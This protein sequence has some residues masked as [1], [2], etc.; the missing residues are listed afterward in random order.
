MLLPNRLVRSATFEGLCDADGLPGA[1]YERLYAEL[2]KSGVGLIIT[3]FCYCSKEGSAI[4]PGQAGL[5]SDD[6]IPAFR[7]VTDAVHAG[8][9]RIAAQIAHTGR[10]TRRAAT[11]HAPLGVSA[12]RSCYF[13]EQPRVLT[14]EKIESIIE[15]L[16]RA[17]ARARAAGFDAVQL[18][19]AHGYLI[20]QF[21]L[22]SINDRRDAWGVKRALGIG[23]A[24][25]GR[26]IE[27]VRAECGEDY[28]L[29]VKVSGSDDLRPRFSRRQFVEL[30]RFLDG[31][32]VDGIEVSYGTMD[33]ALNIFRGSTIPY[34]AILEHDPVYR[35]R[36]AL[37]GR[38][39][40]LF[41][42]PY[43][44]R[45]LEPFSPAYNL[46]YARIA[47][48]N[49][50]AAVIAVGGFR[51]RKEMD[52]VLADGRA[53]FVA[54]CRPFIADRRFATRLRDEEGHVSR[55]ENCN[56]CAVRT[57]AGAATVCRRARP[58]RRAQV[59]RNNRLQDLG[60]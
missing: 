50:D 1:D 41:A 18:H 9:A 23:T 60:R 45:K 38:L 29:L 47:K 17:A 37:R 40:R 11:G 6:K 35:T 44:R 39:W 8:G 26:V 55:C 3:G 16:A 49:T 59:P 13:G 42:A 12:K 24:F 51:G 2:S 48:E 34:E 58:H 46:P 21:I 5:D 54:A 57:G 25:L 22:P 14:S 43:L 15:E 53:D 30:I 20:H 52:R 4:Q 31:Q 19:A 10:Q 28:P 33:H 32:R 27:R 7:K 36:S 56:V